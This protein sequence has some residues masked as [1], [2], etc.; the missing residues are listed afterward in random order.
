MI[1]DS[2]QRAATKAEEI[3]EAMSYPLNIDDDEELVKLAT[4]SLNSK[5]VSQ[6]SWLLAPMAV[7]AIKKIVDMQRDTNVNLN[8]I[9]IVKKLGDTVEES[10][11]ITGALIE[12]KSM[13]HGG[14]SRVEKAKIGLIQ[15]QISPPKTHVSLFESSI[16]SHQN[17]FRWTTKWSFPTMLKWIA[18]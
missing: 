12:Q 8:M 13:G 3:L 1:S 6:Y 7:S 15:F 10:E 4:T 2:F 5:V 9:K 16:C 18:P 14:P 11:L 17:R